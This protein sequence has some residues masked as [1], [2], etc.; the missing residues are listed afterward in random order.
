MTRLNKQR[1][2]IEDLIIES[3][4]LLELSDEEQ[5]MLVGGLVGPWA[6]ASSST[7]NN[8]Y[9]YDS[10]IANSSTNNNDSDYQ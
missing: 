5:Q 4:K 9:D 1:T 2:I 10:G 8:D 6:G 3:K 7:H